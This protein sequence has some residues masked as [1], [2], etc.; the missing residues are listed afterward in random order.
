VLQITATIPPTE[1]V[2][3]EETGTVEAT[4]IPGVVVV[5][6]TA[7]I[8]ATVNAAPLQLYILT[9]DRAYLN[10]DVDG[11]EAFAGRVLPNNV[12]TYSGNEIIHL[13]TGNA[14]ALEVYFNQEYLGNLGG[15]GEVVDVDFTLEGL[16]T[17]SPQPTSTIT[18]EL[19]LGDDAAA[20][21]ESLL[22]TATE[23]MTPEG[24]PESLPDDGTGEM[25]AE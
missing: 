22:A 20:M 18:P 4:P 13:L 3:V 16:E 14:A 24:E 9:H 12:Y 8:V 25:M 15:V 2:E 5:E 7:T 19:G 21:E 1:V 17:P 6:P 10:V 11:A 23:T